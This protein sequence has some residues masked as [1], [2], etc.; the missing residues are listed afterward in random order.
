M[1]NNKTTSKSTSVT[2]TEVKKAKPDKG[3][4][5]GFVK[6]SNSMPNIINE[7][8][9]PG[10]FTESYNP[11]Q[12]NSMYQ[13]RIDAAMNNVINFKYDPLQDANYQALAK[14]YGQRGNIAAKNSVADAAALNGGYGTSFGVSAAQQARNQ[15]NQELAALIPDLEQTAYQRASNA[16]GVLTNADDREY[17][18][19][20]DKEGDELNRLNFEFQKFNANEANRQF[21]YTNRY[22]QLRDAIADWEWAKGYN[23]DYDNHLYSTGQ[24]TVKSSSSGSGGGG[25]GY[26]GGGG[27]IGGSTG[28]S[29][30]DDK[31]PIKK[32]EYD[33]GKYM[34]SFKDRELADEARKNKGKTLL[35][36]QPKPLSLDRTPS[37]DDVQ[38]WKKK[39]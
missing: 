17:G 11:G 34:T 5:L 16:L 7:E 15:Y 25:G 37:L 38:N 21:A 30:D 12:Y 33:N 28:V 24:K 22:N 27:Y 18:R 32:P 9:R 31:P 26:Y 3:N 39:K 29:G 4:G 6:I 13:D 14:V 2:K 23:L 1:A 20:R 19:F 8:Y 36:Y 35:T 10:E